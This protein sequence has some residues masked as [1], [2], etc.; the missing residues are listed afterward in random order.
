MQLQAYEMLS[1]PT[2]RLLYDAN[3]ASE[4]RGRASRTSS[5]PHYDHSSPQCDY[6]QPQDSP[7]GSGGFPDGPSTPQSPY[8]EDANEKVDS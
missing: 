7:G 4:A 2:K 6:S 8:P 5:Q 1:D 3:L